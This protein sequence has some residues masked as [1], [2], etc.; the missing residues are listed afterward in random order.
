MNKVRY[1]GV[2]CHAVFNWF[3]SE[4]YADELYAVI[5]EEF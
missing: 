5:R 2:K 3:V 4:Y 1:D